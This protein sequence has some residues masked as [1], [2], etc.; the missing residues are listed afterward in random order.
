MAKIQSNIW[1]SAA[2]R[3]TPTARPAAPRSPVQPPSRRPL[4]GARPR[5]VIPGL[6]GLPLTLVGSVILTPGDSS[7]VNVDA[8]VNPTRYP[9]EVRELKWTLATAVGVATPGGGTSFSG[10]TVDA[11]IRLSP[12]AGLTEGDAL[13]AAP[14][15]L[16]LLGKA[17]DSSMESFLSSALGGVA[18]A[19]NVIP[20]DEPLYIPPGQG[21]IVRLGHRNLFAASL[22][23]TFAV[24]GQLVDRIPARRAVPYWAPF[25]PLAFSQVGSGNTTDLTRLSTER[26]LA[27]F[28]SGPVRVRRITGRIGMYTPTV[29]YPPLSDTGDGAFFAELLKITSMRSSNGYAI[30]K[31]PMPFSAVFPAQ[32]LALEVPFVLPAKGYINTALKLTAMVDANTTTQIQ[33]AMCLCGYRDVGGK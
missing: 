13:T 23:A 14:V 24:S 1:P 11:S 28:T 21:L 6:P 30:V 12:V 25:I 8:L 29:S 19:T 27:N 18:Q 33:P 2:N 26:D 4:P 32:F 15:P 10:L 31:D 3:S 5:P 22:N 9:L 20:L 16:T 7:D 17:I